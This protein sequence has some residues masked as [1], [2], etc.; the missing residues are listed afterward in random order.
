MVTC[1]PA[2][3]AALP[4]NFQTR[5]RTSARAVPDR[6]HGPL[7]VCGEGVDQAG[8]RRIAGHR[9]QH[10]RLGSAR[11]G[12]ARL[13]SQHAYV[14]QAVPAQGHRES[15]IQQELAWIVHRSGFPPWRQRRRCRLIQTGLMD[16]LHQQYTAGLGHHCTAVVL[17]ADTG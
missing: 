3:G 13:G 10:G 1:P 15:D 4:A 8:D 14:G 6:R 5:L 7:P 9:P 2:S 16:R 17:N 12:S 11:L